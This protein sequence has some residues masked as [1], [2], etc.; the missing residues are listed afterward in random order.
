MS[1]FYDSENY[2]LSSDFETNSLLAELPFQ[3]IKESITEQINDPLST[4]I[5]YIDIIIEKCDAFKSTYENNEDIIRDLNDNLHSFFVSIIEEIDNKFELGLDINT[6]SART[7]V[8]EI[9]EVLY[10]YFILRYVKNISK[11]ITKYIIR[12]KKEL[13][14]YYNDK[15]KKDVSTLAFKKQIKNPDDLSIITNLPSIIK[16]IINL[17]IEP[18]E[19]IDLS[20]GS[21]NY[22]GLT[23]KS[24]IESN[25]MLGDFVNKYIGLSVDNHEYI[26]DEIQTDIKMRLIKKI[27]K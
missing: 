20:T 14:E 23:I 19:F 5:D 18:Y 3:L 8:I 22:E 2:E 4:N 25:Q 10:H 13:A 16:Y 26:I 15:N 6:I 21:D 12:H 27:M 17:D 24:L 11:Y 1:L 9:G 7:D